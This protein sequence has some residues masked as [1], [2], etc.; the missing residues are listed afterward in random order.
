MVKRNVESEALYREIARLLVDRGN[1][2]ALT[3]AGVSAES[4]IP[5]F[6]SKGGLWEKYDPMEFASIEAFRKD[7][8]KYWSLRGEFIK[9]YNRYQPNNAHIALAELEQ[10][11]IVRCVITQN[12][13]GLHK[14][15][16]SKNVIEIHGNLMEIYCLACGKEYKTPNIPD[17]M[18]PHCSCGGI[19]KPN[20]V[21]FGEELPVDVFM[22]A[23]ETSATCRIMLLVGTSAIVHP[24]ASLPYL[25]KENRAKI[26]EINIEKAFPEADYSI[27][28]KAGTALPKI[29]D[30]IN[31]FSHE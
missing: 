7:P 15:A 22:K 8:S 4:G 21:L 27:M 13:D 2:V 16:G 6:R 28:E 23:K 1:C 9:D 26:I 18:P 29:V 20:T 11:G 31:K 12:I 10:M 14:K 30:E 24:A 25:A 19:L 17:G 3:G 5:T